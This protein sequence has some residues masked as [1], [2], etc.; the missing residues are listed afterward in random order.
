[1]NA[2]VWLKYLYREFRDDAL[3]S[4]SARHQQFPDVFF[5]NFAFAHS[6]SVDLHAL[7]TYM[8]NTHET[9]GW[10]NVHH[11]YMFLVVDLLSTHID[12]M[13]GHYGRAVK[14][15]KIWYLFLAYECASLFA[16]LYAVKFIEKHYFNGNNRSKSRPRLAIYQSASAMHG[17]RN[18][19]FHWMSEVVRRQNAQLRSLLVDELGECSVGVWDL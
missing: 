14:T 10:I 2:G 9:G 4:M 11:L 19:G 13:D 18:L 17:K 5:V 6:L 15:M 16:L 8:R 1:M 12:T 3:G 7:D